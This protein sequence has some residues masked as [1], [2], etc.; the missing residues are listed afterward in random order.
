MHQLIN[1]QTGFREPSQ[2]EP[3]KRMRAR[4]LLTYP[5]CVCP[6]LSFS[7]FMVFRLLSLT[8][9]NNKIKRGENHLATIQK[10]GA[11]N[12]RG[13]KFCCFYADEKER[14]KGD[15]DRQREREATYSPALTLRRNLEH[16]GIFSHQ[17][18]PHTSCPIGW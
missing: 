14:K 15:G 4:A 7:P 18:Q 6:P 12:V 2:R 8:W 13:R 9:N 3:R 16:L 10:T 5:I 11:Y 1:C 17:N